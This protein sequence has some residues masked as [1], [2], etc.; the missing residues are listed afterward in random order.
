MI[1][2]RYYPNEKE[3]QSKEFNLTIIKYGRV[4]QNATFGCKVELKNTEN[5]TSVNQSPYK[6]FLEVSVF[7]KA[8]IS[9]MHFI[10]ERIDGINLYPDIDFKRQIIWRN[11][12]DETDVYSAQELCDV[13]FKFLISQI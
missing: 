10:E 9:S 4:L 8:I 3:Y 1:D 12:K 2:A 6:I 7:K 5:A 13:F 11:A